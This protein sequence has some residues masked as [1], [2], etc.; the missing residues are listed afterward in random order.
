MP[1]RN[2]LVLISFL[3]GS[4]ICYGRAPHNRFSPMLDRAMQLVDQYYVEAVPQ[5]ELFENAMKGLASGRD[6]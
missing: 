6:E 3:A 5:R 2:L 4:L 1:L